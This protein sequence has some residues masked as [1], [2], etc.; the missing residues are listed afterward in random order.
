[1]SGPELVDLSNGESRIVFYVDAVDCIAAY[2]VGQKQDH[3]S[4][5]ITLVV[6]MMT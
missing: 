2:R 6:Y 3:F 1:M 5:C 4:K